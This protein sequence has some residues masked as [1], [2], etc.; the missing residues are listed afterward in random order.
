VTAPLLSVRDLTVHFPSDDSVLRAV[1][2]VSFDLAPGEILGIVGESGSGKS[3]TGAAILGLI[4]AIGSCV[5]GSVCFEGRELVGLTN[6]RMR[7]IRGQ[8]IAMVFQDPSMALNPVLTIGRQLDLVLR[9][10]KRLPRPEAR[11]ACIDALRR[12]G[13]SLPEERLDAYPHQLS[14][15]QRQRVAIAAA[16]MHR[17]KLII[18]DEP[19]T[20]LDVSTQAQILAEMRTRIAQD[21][22]ALIWI[23]HDLAVVASLTPRI[24]VMYA[25]RVV[26]EGPTSTVLRTP[27]HPYTR[28]MLDSLPGEAAPGA[29]LTPIPG[30]SATAADTGCSFAPRCR[31]ADDACRIAPPLTHEGAVSYRCHHP[32]TGA[33]A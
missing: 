16:L 27:R 14:G 22:S 29:E 10:H 1:D 2:G 13:L 17:P 5:G 4:D 30:T 15:G 7:E 20:A 9:A 33:T 31:H 24:A 23:S 11:A 19:T 8:S 18:A 12:V 6:A 25:G 32:L 3:A 21:G 28:G 26:E